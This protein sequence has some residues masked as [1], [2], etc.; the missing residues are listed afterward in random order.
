VGRLGCLH[1]A[2]RV[3]IRAHLDAQH[4]SRDCR[5]RLVLVVVFL[6]CRVYFRCRRRS[7]GV[8]AERL[9][10]GA[11]VGMTRLRILYACDQCRNCLVL[12]FGLLPCALDTR[13]DGLEY[14]AP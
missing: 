4:V 13:I 6:D 11:V 2:H 9:V 12:R 5:S 10:N 3:P 8:E 1:R 7:L 14:P